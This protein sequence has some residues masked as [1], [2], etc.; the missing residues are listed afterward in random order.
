MVR[1]SAVNSWQAARDKQRRHYGTG[2]C[3]IPEADATPK[4][5]WPAG[6]R[7]SQLDQL[8]LRQAL[9]GLWELLGGRGT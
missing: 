4:A 6:Q 7:G 1:A 8:E 5:M 3:C 2:R 9:D